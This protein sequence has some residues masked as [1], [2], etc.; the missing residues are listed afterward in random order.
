MN[1]QDFAKVIMRQIYNVLKPAG[2]RKRRN[3]FMAER[4]DVVLLI[5]LQKS[6]RTTRNC[7][8]VTIN[9]GV[10]SPILRSK[11][12]Y[13]TQRPAMIYSQWQER[14]GFLLPE[15]RDKWWTVCDEEQALKVAE[16]IA[17]VIVKYGLPTLEE[18][19]STD[20]LRLLWE[21]GRSPGL[22]EAERQRYLRILSE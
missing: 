4:N 11:L 10:F 19:S 13:A 2:F 8:I 22:T 15:H 20:K 5:Q 14:I 7:L 16:E 21:S 1:A 6:L 18:L 3:T 9:L 12:G 17:G